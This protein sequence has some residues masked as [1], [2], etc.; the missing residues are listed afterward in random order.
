MEGDSQELSAPTDLTQH[1]AKDL[2]TTMSDLSELE[3]QK[4]ELLGDQVARLAETAEHQPSKGNDTESNEVGLVVTDEVVASESP[5]IP[6]AVDLEEQKSGEPAQDMP[7]KGGEDA[8]DSPAIPVEEH[9][10]SL[11]IGQEDSGS[12]SEVEALMKSEKEAEDFLKVVEESK[13]E[14]YE[15]LLESQK[16]YDALYIAYLRDIRHLSKR[17]ET[18]YQEVFAERRPLT[19]DIENFWLTV[20]KN[21]PI[22]ADTIQAK[23]EPLLR[24]LTDISYNSADNGREFTIKLEFSENPVM[25]NTVL[26]KTF[27]LD[28]DDTLKK[29]HSSK[30]NWKADDLTMKKVVETKKNKR[31]KAVKKVTKYVSDDSFFNLFKEIEDYD[32]SEYSEED[33]AGMLGDD[34]ELGLELRDEVVNYAFLLFTGARD[35]AEEVEEDEEES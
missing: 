11:P 24:H 33:I 21:D 1:D 28:S 12:D 34:L 14:A 30:V 29:S 7:E 16:K 3:E 18:K 20:L 26:T 8:E 13:S 25:H 31:S 4:H 23:D 10:R 15:A 17:T 19:S 6:A 35:L 9:K 27:L 32:D 5:L 2:A 22:I